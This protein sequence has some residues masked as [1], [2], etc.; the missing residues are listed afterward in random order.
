[1]LRRRALLTAGSQYNDPK[2]IQWDDDGGLSRPDSN[3]AASPNAADVYPG[4]FSPTA[5]EW[6]SFFLMSLGWFVLLTSL[7]GFWR[8]K[9]WE[10]GIR[11]ANETP[12]PAATQG[13]NAVFMSRVLTVFGIPTDDDGD[14][15]PGDPEENS[16]PPPTEED[17]R[18]RRDL[19]ASGL[20]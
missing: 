9:R 7:L 18:L 10:R 2:D 19:R 16:E 17:V 5:T 8:V 15:E 4:Y 11:Q 3:E 1:L 6:I 14:S 20:L 12:I 13:D